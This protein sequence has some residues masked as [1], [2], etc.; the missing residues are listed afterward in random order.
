[1]RRLVAWCLLMLICLALCAC[2]LG[3]DEKTTTNTSTKA[4]VSLSS[5][6]SI[7]KMLQGVWYWE[8]DECSEELYFDK[9]RY[10]YDFFIKNAPEAYGFH[11]GS[12]SIKDGY[13][14]IGSDSEHIV[15]FPYEISN[16]EL[17]FK[18]K[19]DSGR[20]AGVTRV[21]RKQYGFSED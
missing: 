1:M 4:K 21:Y 17:I 9:G 7:D 3:E 10:S 11:T 13:I 6:E 8:D 12:Y 19:I 18:R 16:G 15:L 2:D 14:R 20:D 5:P